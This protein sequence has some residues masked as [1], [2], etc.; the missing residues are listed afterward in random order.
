MTFA[1]EQP[2]VP[3]APAHLSPDATKW[4]NDVVERFVLES[5]DLRLLQLAAE[6]W[7]RCQEARALLADQGL[8]IEGRQGSKPHPAAGIARDS[9]ITFARL[10]RELDLGV[11]APVPDV[12]PPPLA[13][14]NGR[15][16]HAG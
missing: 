5:H 7:D 14:N 9:A 4:W 15:R 11:A 1:L 8:V 2:P 16:R 10:V 3:P 13:S 12:R 6:A